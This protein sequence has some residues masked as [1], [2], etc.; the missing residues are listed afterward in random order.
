MKFFVLPGLM[1]NITL[2]GATLAVLTSCTSQRRVPTNIPPKVFQYSYQE[3]SRQIISPTLSRKLSSGK[4]GDMV[5]MKYDNKSS[6]VRLGKNY[7]SANGYM[8][9][10]YTVNPSNEKAA[11]KINNRWYQA[12]PILIKK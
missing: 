4:S 8:C 11:C 5:Y 7:Y 3:P 6:T 2:L 9:R 12:K 1:T 10:Y